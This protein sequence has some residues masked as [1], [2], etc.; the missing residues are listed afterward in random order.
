MRPPWL[1][2]RVL[3]FTVLVPC[4][5][6]A[7]APYY[8]IVGPDRVASRWPP[9]AARV[10]GLIPFAIGLAIYVVCAWR[11]AAEGLGTPAPWDPPRRLVTGGLFRWTRNPF[12]VGI[13]SI[14][15]GEAVL[16]SSR[17]LVWYTVV[18][19]VAFHL[20]VTLHEEP[21]LR[22][23]FG[24]EFE[25]YSN[26]VPRWLPPFGRGDRGPST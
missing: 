17:D 24:A 22:R 26:A 13:L 3:S 12:Y 10:W 8:W 21:A 18:V 25:R 6:V 15:A 9:S 19:A 1:L 23:L 5:V 20:R 2:L 11:F 14:L 16:L 4:T 7:W